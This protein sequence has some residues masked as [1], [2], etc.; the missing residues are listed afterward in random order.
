M[1]MYADRRFFERKYAAIGARDIAVLEH[2]KTPERFSIKCRYTVSNDA[3]IPE[4]AKKFLGREMVVTQQDEWDIAKRTGRL[5]LE[6]KG[7]PAKITAEM[8]LSDE[9]KGSVNLMQWT[10][11]CRIP[12]VGGKL[13]KIIADDIRTRSKSD[14]AASRTILADY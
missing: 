6:L 12:L 4:L 11:D 10:V 9:G 3:A 7:T 2:E 1:G 13:E 14:L 8:R 5:Q